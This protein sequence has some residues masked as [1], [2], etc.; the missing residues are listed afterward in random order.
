MRLHLLMILVLGIVLFGC[1]LI[2]VE[3]IIGCWTRNSSDGKDTYFYQ[4]DSF[5]RFVM[6]SSKYGTAT[7]YYNR[8][9]QWGG[10]QYKLTYDPPAVVGS[11]VTYHPS[12]D[13]LTV[14]EGTAE[15]VRTQCKGLFLWNEIY[16]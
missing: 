2:K 12:Q 8:M 16:P 7:G 13:T 4:F 6:E 9:P 14:G 3:P 15:Y 5:K 1:T 11:S 10:Y